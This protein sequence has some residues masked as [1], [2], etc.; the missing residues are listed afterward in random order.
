MFNINF[1]NLVAFLIWVGK[2]KAEHF[3]ARLFQF[4]QTEKAN[5]WI[6]T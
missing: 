2:V 5:Q 3:C 1:F 4:L 6:K